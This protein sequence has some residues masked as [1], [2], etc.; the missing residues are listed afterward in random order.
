MLD[1][2]DISADGRRFALHS[3]TDKKKRVYDVSGDEPSEV[4]SLDIAYQGNVLLSPDGRR[5]LIAAEASS[6]VYDVKD[7]ATLFTVPVSIRY[8][9]FTRT[10]RSWLATRGP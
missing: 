9:A 10:G 7:G 8:A 4:L 3:H 2:V 6:T 1:E 5:L